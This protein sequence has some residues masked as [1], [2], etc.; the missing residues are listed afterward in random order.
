ML[1]AVSATGATFPPTLF[2][3]P[4]APPIAM[5]GTWAL[6]VK[7]GVVCALLLNAAR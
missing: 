5:I 3:R 2:P 1:F 6:F 4:A 7:R